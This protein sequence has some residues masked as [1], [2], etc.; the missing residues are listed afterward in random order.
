MGIKKKDI[1]AKLSK[2]QAGKI[3][4]ETGKEMTKY[5]CSLKEKRFYKGQILK[6]Q[7]IEVEDDIL[8]QQ[9]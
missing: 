8:N 7:T 2:R 6:R 4:K 3:L 9:N 1:W 5:N